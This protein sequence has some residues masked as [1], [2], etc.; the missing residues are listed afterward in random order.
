MLTIGCGCLP[1]GRAA[2]PCRQQQRFVSSPAFPERASGSEQCPKSK[3]KLAPYLPYVRER[4]A[5]GTHN[6]LQLFR[7]IKGRGYTGGRALLGGLIAQWRTELPPK[8]RQ[9]K[10][11]KA[12]LTAPEGQ[13]SQR[14]LSSRRAAFLLILSPEKLTALQRQQ[15]EQICQSSDELHTVYRL[16]QEFLTLLKSR[17]VEQFTSAGH[18]AEERVSYDVA[19]A[20]LLQTALL[21]CAM[22]RER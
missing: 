17:K 5:A 16:S 14:R 3:S 6:G 7:E 8:A 4:W 20:N 2:Q 22:L 9:G 19:K 18:L 15:L 13:V 10:P 1:Q 12:R 21:Q 11:R